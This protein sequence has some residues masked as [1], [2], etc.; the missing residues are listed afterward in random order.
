M[1]TDEQRLVAHHSSGHARVTAVAGAGKTSTMVRFVLEQLK[2]G[3]DPRLIRVVMFNKAAQEDFSSKL[4]LSA[5]PSVTLPPVRTFHAMGRNLA[6]SLAREGY[7]PT[8]DPTPLSDAQIAIEMLRALQASAGTSAQRSAIREEQQQWLDAF[9]GF[10]DLAKSSLHTPETC[11][12]TAGYADQ[13]QL[14]IEAFARFEKWRKAE[15][16][17]TFSDYLYDPC[18]AIAAKPELA[19]FLANRVELFVVDEFQDINDIQFFLLKTLAGDRARMQVVGDADQCI[20]EFRGAR[21]EYML[22]HFGESYP[23]RSYQ[24]SRTFRYGHCLALA[25][26]HLIAHNQRREPVLCISAETAPE[27]KI[28]LCLQT[29]DGFSLAE[30][31]LAEYKSGRPFRDMVF[32]CRT[33]AQ[34]APVELVLLQRGIPNR[35]AGGSRVLERQET[36]VLMFLLRVMAGQF[37]EQDA[38]DC[39]QQ[40]YDFLRFCELKIKHE[41]LR[42]Y[43]LRS[44]QNGAGFNALRM[45]EDSL[46][47]Y[48]EQRLQRVADAL[49]RIEKSASAGAGVAAFLTELDLLK[50]I[51]D[52]ALNREDGENR[53]ATVSAFVSFI[54]MQKDQTP[55]AMVSLIEGLRDTGSKP[56]D[57]AL[58]TDAVTITTMHRSKG[59]EWPVVILPGLS[60]HYMPYQAGNRRRPDDEQEESERRLMYVAMTRAINALYLFAPGVD[61]RNGWDG[62]LRP[63]LNLLP[64]PFLGEMNIPLATELGASISKGDFENK[65]TIPQTPISSRY[66]EALALADDFSSDNR[67]E[68]RLDLGDVVRHRHHGEGR[69]VAIDEHG[70][71]VQ[72]DTGKVYFS[73][74]LVNHVLDIIDGPTEGAVLSDNSGAFASGDVLAHSKFGRGVVSS[75]DE[76]FIYIR[77]RDGDRTFRRD[78]FHATRIA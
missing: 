47:V 31:C 8:F 29:M 44:L 61:C 67:G 66:L 35:I 2:S 51:R 10:V 33:W 14:F 77:F 53:A 7:L 6:I 69:V 21:P 46:S 36:K 18:L 23:H 5:G 55:S 54:A 1:L 63:E 73:S 22:K 16:R 42:G 24:M 40:I 64:S 45:S 48:Q 72:F 11:F 76:R 28:E 39:E 70:M 4:Q 3:V 27:T 50:S 56:N 74:I 20:Y 13:Y 59:L 38:S 68:A 78:L 37:F 17:V 9:T 32:L 58:L 26:A 30:V 15:A 62:G 43:A 41:I 71:A 19:N 25:A 65:L 49:T 60:A 52:N 12:F 57:S 75:V 34:A